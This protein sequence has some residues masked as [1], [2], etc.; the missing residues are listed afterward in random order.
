M[1]LLAL[2]LACTPPGKPGDT[3]TIGDGGGTTPTD[4]GSDGGSDGGTSTTEP[5]LAQAEVV[6]IGAGA[7]GLAAGAGAQE[8]GAEVIVLE[9][10]TTWGGAGR[11]ARGYFAVQTRWQAEAG[12]V[13]SVELALEEW[14][15]FTG[16]DASNP[17]VVNFLSESEDVLLWL[18]G[19]G[20][21]FTAGVEAPTDSGSVPRVHDFSDDGLQPVDAMKAALGESIRYSTTAV[22]L[23][24]DEDRVIGVVVEQADGSSG[25]IEAGAVVVATGGFG[26]NDLRVAV[27][28]PG[29]EAW[30]VYYESHPGMD[31]N[32]L[33][34]VEQAG[35]VL[36][37]PE[38]LAL[39]THSVPD[40]QIGGSETMVVGGLCYTMMVDA[41]GQRFASELDAGSGA[42]GA[43]Y[44]AR[45]PL[46]ALVDQTRFLR[47]GFSGRGFNYTDGSMPNRLDGPEYE[48]LSPFPSAEDVEGLA[49]AIGLDEASLRAAADRYNGL[50]AAGADTDF[51]KS[52][53][54]LQPLLTPPFRAIPLVMARAKSFSGASMGVQGEVLDG[55]GE[56][57]P[58]LYAAGEA[59]GFLG[60]PWAGHGFNGSV[61]AAVW[62]GRRAGRSA[63]AW[64]G[65]TG[66]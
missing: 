6:V 55:S 8:A 23:V 15:D 42:R 66:D 5:P 13:D 58:G 57:I 60:G 25:W 28:R 9:R 26:R 31:G 37:N 56:A 49:R 3:A 17:A 39:L 7:S 33:D 52:G 47:L 51:G 4:G 20:V 46:F 59:G 65:A 34:L 29:V 54:C 27:A 19:M 35:G 21:G 62:S 14:P 61:S 30:P 63:A 53:D 32:G 18:E 10:E 2:A 38:G 45:G 24:M 50:V 11:H 64:A 48:A 40:P 41:T 43:D 1:L 16:G 22:D 44:L 12:I 36:A